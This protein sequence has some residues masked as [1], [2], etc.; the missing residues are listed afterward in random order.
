MTD[1]LSY[2]VYFLMG[3]IITPIGILVYSNLKKSNNDMQKA[4]Y[5]KIHEELKDGIESLNGTLDRMTL[6][7]EING[8]KI[9]YKHIYMNRK[10]FDGYINSGEFNTINY[11]F[12]Q[13]I[14][15]IYGKIE[16][17]DNLV[18]KIE[19]NGYSL[20]TDILNLNKI[21]KELINEVPLIMEK[22]RKYF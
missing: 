18:K 10:V 14:Q 3:G 6:Q 21:E 4:I 5:Q 20:N 22:L 7:H 19:T 1:F 15:D 16:I 8:K 9:N 17:H 13:P 11:K 2:V 12:Q